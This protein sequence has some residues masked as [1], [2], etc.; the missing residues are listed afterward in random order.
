VKLN[1]K[2]QTFAAVLGLAVLCTGCGG[3]NA[4]R[5]VSPLNIFMPATLLQADPKLPSS[6]PVPQPAPVQLLAQSQP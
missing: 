3:V 5:S 6:D 4:S 1:W 2:Y